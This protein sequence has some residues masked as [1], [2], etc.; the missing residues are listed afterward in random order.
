MTSVGLPV[1]AYI[2][3]ALLVLQLHFS[4]ERVLYVR[5]AFSNG[6]IYLVLMCFWQTESDIACFVLSKN[7]VCSSDVCGQ[8]GA[9][10]EVGYDCM[11]I[12]KL[13]QLV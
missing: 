2:V 10:W 9:E 3:F 1:R 6:E 7:E 8:R 4:N 11:S 13:N 12:S 5:A